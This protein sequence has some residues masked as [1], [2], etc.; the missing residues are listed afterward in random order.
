MRITNGEGVD[1]ILD[2]Q[3]PASFRK[4]YRLL[5]QG[6]RLVMFG[7]ADG[8]DRQAEHPGAGQGAHRDA[9]GDDA[10]VEERQHDE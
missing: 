8:A 5:R 1:V 7:F 3:G 4:D 6:G 10:L 9:A 2:A